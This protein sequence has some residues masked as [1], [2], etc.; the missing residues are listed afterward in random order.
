VRQADGRVV[1]VGVVVGP[2]DKDFLIVRHRPDG[3]KDALFGVDGRVLVG[4]GADDTA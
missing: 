2:N 1:S 4:F 3:I